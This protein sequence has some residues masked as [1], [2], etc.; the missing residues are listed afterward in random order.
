MTTITDCIFGKCNCPS[1]EQCKFT[2]C[3]NCDFPINDQGKTLVDH[4][5]EEERLEVCPDCGGPLND[6]HVYG[7]L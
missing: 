2:R 3:G 6:R 1:A 5:C 4:G 7:A